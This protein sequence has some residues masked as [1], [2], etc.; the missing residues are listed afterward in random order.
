MGVGRPHDNVILI[1]GLIFKDIDLA[2][3]AQGELEDIFGAVNKK[4]PVL[5]FDKTRYYEDEIGAGLKRRFLS[6]K[7]MIRPEDPAGI[8]IT[9][10][11][12]ESR[13]RV[14]GNRAVNI[15]PGY[16]TEAKLVLLT[17][18]DNQHRIYLRDGIFAEV[19]LMYRKGTFKPLEW[20]YPDYRG[21]D[22]IDF[23]NELREDM[24]GCRKK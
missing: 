11:G 1:T 10:N 13:L 12:I 20:T 15:D 16:L 6:F 5:E 2:N 7:N 21:R 4:S 17:T 23:F 19:T 24:V 18:K 14:K 8:K 3:R 22:Y 9:T